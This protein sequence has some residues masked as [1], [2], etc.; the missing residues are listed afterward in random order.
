MQELAMSDGCRIQYRFDGDPERP[1]ILLSNSLSSTLEMWEPQIP[2]LTERFRVLRYDAR[3]HGRSEVAPGPYEMERLA[4]D[5]K[6][7]IEGAAA[8]CPVAFCGLSMGG[9]VGMWLASN[10]PGLLTRAVFA[11]TSAYFGM[12]DVWNQRIAGVEAGGMQVA[13]EATIQRW[14]SQDFRDKNP[15]VTQKVFDMIANTP[16][17]GYIAA[18]SAVRDVDLRAGLPSITTPVLVIAGA[19]DPSTPPAMGEA[20]VEA[21]P[22]ARLAIL[23]A[24]HM[25]N[26]ESA[27]E[28]SRLV[29]SFL[30]TD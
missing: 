29:I 9:M 1:V 23:D 25:S 3:G 17:A 28:F 12:P 11:N 26:I 13:A 6:E 30:A 2:V 5:A 19:L 14:L 15:G 4:R 27:E 8:G 21:I 18:A 20:I 16:A 22:D 24:A 10:A 7:L